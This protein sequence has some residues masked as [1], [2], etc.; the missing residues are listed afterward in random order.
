MH[1]LA[2]LIASVTLGDDRTVASLRNLSDRD[3]W[4]DFDDEEYEY[5][6]AK[7]LPLFPVVRLSPYS[8]TG[9]AWTL[10]SLN[11]GLPVRDIAYHLGRKYGR[12]FSAREVRAMMRALEFK[13]R[14]TSRPLTEKEDHSRSGDKV[15]WEV[16]A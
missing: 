4:F 16:A 8:L 10:L 14:V 5:E 11:N 6:T 15:L 13:K 2:D 3:K 1:H 7:I 9:E 12:Y